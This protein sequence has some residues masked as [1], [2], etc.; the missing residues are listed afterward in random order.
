LAVGAFFISAKFVY[1]T[2]ITVDAACVDVAPA[3][4]ICDDV[5]TYKTITEAVAV[6]LNSDVITIAAG[7]YNEAVTIGTGITL[8]GASDDSVTGT[9]L[10]ST[11]AGYGVT[12][13]SSNVSLKNLRIDRAGFGGGVS[14]AASG[15]TT[16]LTFDGITVTGASNSVNHLVSPYVGLRVSGGTSI[17]GLTVTNSHFDGNDIGWYLS[18]ESAAVGGPTVTNVSVTGTTFSNNLMKGIYAEKLDHATFTNITVANSGT[19]A[20]YGFNAGIDIN[21]KW[22]NYSEITIESS[23]ITGSGLL[24]SATSPFNPASVTIKAR[25]DAPSYASPAASLTNVTLSDLTISGGYNALRFGET[26]KAN[27]GPTNV[28]VEE[29]S[30]TAT[31]LALINATTTATINAANN[32]WGVSSRPA[33]VAKVAGNATIDPYYIDF[34]GGTLASNP[35]VTITAGPQ[36]P[37]ATNNTTPEFFFNSVTGGATFECSV[38]GVATS[39][40]SSPSYTSAALGA[41]AHIFTVVVT[42]PGT[43][44]TGSAS[45]NFTIDLTAPT[46]LVVTPVPSSISDTT[47]NFTFSSDEAGT[48]VYGGDCSSGT[49]A[50]TVGN[51]TVTFDALPQGLH[52][53][54]SVSVTDA[55]GNATSTALAV[56]AFTVDTLGPT[57]AFSA[58]TPSGSFTL[59]DIITLKVDFNE[60]AETAYGVTLNLNSGGTCNL[61]T[62]VGTTTKNCDYTVALGDLAANL[63]VTSFTVGNSGHISDVLGN[64][65]NTSPTSNI[66][67]GYVVDAVIPTV[68][69]VNTN[70][71][72]GVYAAGVN[73]DI[74]VTFSENV[75][76][77]G[78]PTLA[79]NSGGTATY[80]S[81]SGT[82]VLTFRYTTALGDNSADLGYVNTN[83]LSGT[84]EDINTNAAD[85]TLPAVNTFL[86]SHG[87]VI[88]TAAPVIS[89]VAFNPINGVLNIGD[90][91][92]V[93]IDAD[94][95]GYTA[96]A[97]TINGVSATGFTDNGNTTYTVTY[98]VGSGD[99]DRADGD[100]I[101]VSVVLTDAATNSNTAF[102]TAP[103]SGSTP[104]VDANAPAAPSTPN[105]DTASDSGSSSSDDI[106]SDT[107]P[108]FSGTAEVGSTVTL[109]DGASP[110]GSAIASAGSWTIT[111]SLLSEGPHTITAH[112]TDV[113]G[114]VGVLSSG[115]SLTIDTTAPA[116][117]EIT[118]V[119]T[120]FNNA[121]PS[122]TFS[123]NEAGTAT[124][125]G[126]CS[127]TSS[128]AA[129]SGQNVFPFNTLSEGAHTNCT[130]TVTD[131]AGNPSSVLAVTAFTIDLTVPT[132]VASSTTANGY[133][134]GGDTI[135][136][137]LT[138]SEPV[139]STDSLTVT[140][141]TGATDQTCV[142][143]ALTSA[144]TGSCFYTVINGDTSSDLMV[145]SIAVNNGGTIKDA[146]NNPAN[147][148]PTSNIS[149][150]SNIVVDTTAPSISAGPAIFTPSNDNTPTFTF[151]STEAGAITYGGAGGCTSTSTAAVAG[152]NSIT[153]DTLSD[154][155][156]NNSCNYFVTDLAGNNSNTLI[157]LSFKIDTVAPTVAATS[158]NIAGYYSTIHSINATLTFSEPILSNKDLVVTFSNGGTCT[159]P[160][161]SPGQTVSCN[162]AIQ[163]GDDITDISVSSITLAAPGSITDISNNPANLAPTSNIGLGIH[164]DTVAP[165]I[166]LVGANPDSVT[167]NQVYNNP[168]ATADDGSTV[169][170][171]GMVNTANVGTYTLNYDATDLAGNNALTANRTVYVISDPNAPS[172]F[173]ATTTNFDG[174]VSGTVPV[175]TTL[176]GG[177]LFIPAGTVITGSSAWDGGILAPTATSNFSGPDAITGF[178]LSN[179]SA[180]EVGSTLSPLTLSQPVRIMFPNKLGYFAGYSSN[181]AYSHV[182]MTCAG[183]DMAA[184][185]PQIS[186]GSDCKMNS[187]QNLVVWTEH[188]TP[189]ITFAVS[190]NGTVTGTGGGG[191]GNGAPVAQPTQQGSTGGEV[192][193]V[194]TFNFTRDLRI[195]STGEDV[196]ALQ[197]ILI[198]QGYMSGEATG[199]FGNLTSAAVKL[200]QKARGISQT[201]TVGPLTRAS[202]N[203]GSPTTSSSSS[204]TTGT[205]ALSKTQA[206]AIL[207]LLAS[208]GADQS[209][210]D[211]VKKALGY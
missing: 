196:T 4:G 44:L 190:P 5:N 147:L 2:S 95:T 204:T 113:A 114:N 88:D 98:T 117:L 12:I 163:P 137:T 18:Q 135:D 209:I 53:N 210:I 106:T 112:A 199:Y 164:V 143:G 69:V 85:L 75:V 80:L 102:T 90:D 13:T 59:G 79:L 31:N 171:S 116:I 38:D 72:D 202:L 168:G 182:S 22:S 20:T 36:D 187:G 19:D 51:N 191:G 169:V 50:A 29:S 195:G 177:T 192:L 86:G 149:N 41:G 8:Q 74:T 17:D 152:S 96:G 184:V 6:A 48:I 144:T 11:A 108:T 63:L 70:H 35:I 87:I 129:S 170:A 133:Y 179:I 23:T 89:S 128:F 123:S 3:N 141:E 61:G 188:M 101:P 40:C 193:G 207:G 57:L 175:D 151:T 30:I 180:V 33:I 100:Q 9:I 26:N 105:L 130:T 24:G 120:P 115:L 208:F 58:V 82:N 189:F 78:S 173:V 198:E 174:T 134:N 47:P 160:A 121:T 119:P 64:N 28:T 136:V 181:G 14:I 46:L 139:T 142:I 45:S 154:G 54:C 186:V 153:Y 15:T 146:A 60:P 200:Y 39:S 91:L 7:T 125:G 76:V 71:S 67:P 62:F 194:T 197:T 162:Y 178:T 161:P 107:T 34:V 66:A 42:D 183:D 132:V 68:T 81:G 56:P 201:G 73:I 126:D 109:F 156:Y 206:D 93:T 103:P 148:T 83:S 84:I 203:A 16:N 176:G 52:N 172:M 110:V 205:P 32:Y 185:D 43:F 145:S 99:T 25:D 10:A 165:V 122:N 157:H 127:N 138:F 155:E 150:T 27:T 211:S 21:L 94:A 92:I 111:S 49:T 65:A 131:A 77:A 124:F 97:I 37:T 166:T 104:A 55:A 167:H 1:A 118:P 159:I 140:L 158:T